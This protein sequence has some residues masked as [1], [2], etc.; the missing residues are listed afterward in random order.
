MKEENIGAPHRRLLY[1]H[2][3]PSKVCLTELGRARCRP[4]PLQAMAFQDSKKHLVAERVSHQSWVGRRGK[5]GRKFV[6]FIRYLVPGYLSRSRTW[7]PGYS[8]L[9]DMK[10][11]VE[12]RVVVTS[13]LNNSSF[14]TYLYSP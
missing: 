9:P 2:C 13:T 8:S 1:L 4:P 12:N 14:I 5:G 6:N 7:L 11:Y 10:N 3:I